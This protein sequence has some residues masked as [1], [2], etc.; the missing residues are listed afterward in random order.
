M[1]GQKAVPFSLEKALAPPP[2]KIRKEKP[3]QCQFVFA[4]ALER[5]A[6]L[7]VGLSVNA[8]MNLERERERKSL[9]GFLR[10]PMCFMWVIW[11]KLPVWFEKDEPITSFNLFFCFL[12][13]YFL[14]PY[15]HLALVSSTLLSA[16]VWANGSASDLIST[17]RNRPPPLAANG[18]G[19]RSSTPRTRESSRKSVARCIGETSDNRSR[20][21]LAQQIQIAFSDYA[22][23]HVG[24]SDWLL[25]SNGIEFTVVPSICGD[26]AL[27]KN[28]FQTGGFEQHSSCRDG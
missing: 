12:R 13:Y 6:W 22:S 4:H 16:F 23:P 21:W 24:L 25:K 10:S 9:N 27:V 15:R 11:V 28:R 20:I 26:F 7:M 19:F 5:K 17:N 18:K 3:T 2:Q 1:T 8:R 14:L